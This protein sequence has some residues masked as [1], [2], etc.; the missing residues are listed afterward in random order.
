MFEVKTILTN[1]QVGQVRNLLIEIIKAKP[2][3][4]NL[5]EL[6]ALLQSEVEFDQIQS[7]V[8][9]SIRNDRFKDNRICINLKLKDYEFIIAQYNDQS[10]REPSYQE[11]A[12]LDRRIKLEYRFDT[13]SVF[14]FYTFKCTG[15]YDPL[16]P[17]LDKLNNSLIE[18]NK[19]TPGVWWNTVSTD[20]SDAT[21]FLVTRTIFPLL[22][23]IEKVVD[24]FVKD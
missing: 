16:I 8:L 19:V 14:S 21:E 17:E 24:L 10:D 5:E 18:S 22:T 11:I 2:N 23:G 4:H 12:I 3:R 9:Y 13:Q 7:S 1:E 6:M 15:P 20:V